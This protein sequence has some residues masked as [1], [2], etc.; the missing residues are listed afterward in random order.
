[1]LSFTL[2]TSS[3]LRTLQLYAVKLRRHML[4][5]TMHKLSLQKSGSHCCQKKDESTSINCQ[6]IVGARKVWSC[7]LYDGMIFCNDL[8]FNPNFQVCSN[9]SSSFILAVIISL[10]MKKQKLNCHNKYIP[11]YVMAHTIEVEFL[12]MSKAN[13]DDQQ[14]VFVHIVIQESEIFPIHVTARA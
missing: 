7:S 11:N 6:F 9:C 5:S 3:K 1:M 10:L 13:V 2:F 14:V 4:L 8:H 12:F